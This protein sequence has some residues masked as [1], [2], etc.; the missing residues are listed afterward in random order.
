MLTLPIIWQQ[1]GFF[2]HF[3]Q[4]YS[5]K[6]KQ[7]ILYKLLFRKF[8][9]IFTAFFYQNITPDIPN[10]LISNILLIHLQIKIF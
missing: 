4:K 5:C 10:Y 8:F 3:T 6:F 1:I 2:V 7:N 9:L